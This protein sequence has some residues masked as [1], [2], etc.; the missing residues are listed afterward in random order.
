MCSR[1]I[2]VGSARN[3]YSNKIKKNKESIKNNI[4]PIHIKMYNFNFNIYNLI[5]NSHVYH[6]LYNIIVFI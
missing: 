2:N 6:R 3:L 1:G 5:Q 4:N